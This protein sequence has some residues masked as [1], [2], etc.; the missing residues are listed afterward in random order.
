[1]KYLATY[2]GQLFLI[3]LATNFKN[4]LYK[5][6]SKNSR[7]KEYNKKTLEIEE[8]NNVYGNFIPY[9]KTAFSLNLRNEDS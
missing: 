5:K 2:L 4:E 3:H 7:L 9:Q 6:I 8:I 1:M